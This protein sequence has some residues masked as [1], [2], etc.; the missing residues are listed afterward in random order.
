MGPRKR[1]A[2]HNIMTVFLSKHYE[3]KNFFPCVFGLRGVGWAGGRGGIGQSLRHV[4]N[5]AIIV[6]HAKLE[7]T[8]TSERKQRTS[9]Y[10][11]EAT[12]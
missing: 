10:T 11:T 2:M 4:N 6:K 3:V 1:R 8:W 5:Y 9:T 7:E 12:I